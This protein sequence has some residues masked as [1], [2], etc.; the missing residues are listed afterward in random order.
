MP[1][2][3]IIPISDAASPMISLTRSIMS[4][5]GM[6]E[7]ESESSKK[8][9]REYWNQHMDDVLLD[10]FLHQYQ[11]GNKVNGTFTTQAYKNILAE[12]NLKLEKNLTKSNIQNRWKTLKTNF[13]NCY[14]LFKT[15]LSGF[16][17]NPTN[18]MFTA[19][20]E[21][22][23]RLIEAHP[24]AKDWMNKPIENYD[25]MVILYGKDRA[26]G[27]HAK[28]PKEMRQRRSSEVH[29]ELMDNI[30]GMDNLVDRNEVTLENV[31]SAS[32]GDMDDEN[33]QEVHSHTPAAST[34]KGKKHKIS[35]EDSLISSIT[36]AT[37]GMVGALERGT[38]SLDRAFSRAF[39]SLPIPE[40]DVYKLLEDLQIGPKYLMDAFFFLVEHPEKLKAIL[41]CPMEMRKTMIMR[42]AFGPNAP[43][44]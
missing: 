29:E 18:K 10:A 4:K 12:V 31:D 42:G 30:D 20:P 33:G 23:E 21:V 34:S 9:G 2:S 25:K 43:I 17:W 24:K 36:N 19:E 27:E 6:N 1:D 14:D 8:E 22:W 16:T 28:T 13:S 5:R 11:I 26:T 41:A 32:T 3:S 37:Q 39:P 44:N 38:D 40:G 15:G 7:S 35:K